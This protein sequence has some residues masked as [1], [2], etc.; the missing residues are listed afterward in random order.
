MIFYLLHSSLHC[1]LYYFSIFN[2]ITI[3][4]VYLFLTPNSRSAFRAGVSLNIHSFIH[5]FTTIVSSAG[6]LTE[7]NLVPHCA[8][9]LE[10]PV[11]FTFKMKQHSKYL[12]VF[13]EE[14]IRHFCPVIRIVHSYF[15]FSNP[16][17]VV[18]DL[19]WRNRKYFNDLNKKQF[20]QHKILNISRNI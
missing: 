10:K 6:T 13:V 16:Q 7:L 20:K 3:S 12:R 8:Y 4:C 5:S 17:F 2:D 19:T 9:K 1:V 11:H 14:N 15:S 18:S